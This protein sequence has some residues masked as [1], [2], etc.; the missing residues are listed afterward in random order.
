M[1][2]SMMTKTVFVCLCVGLRSLCLSLCL[3]ISVFISVSVSVLDHHFMVLNTQSY[4]W[5]GLGWIGI[6]YL[7]GAVFN[8]EYLV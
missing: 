1:T 8:R 5:M 3:P 6:G 4:M 7:P 2:D